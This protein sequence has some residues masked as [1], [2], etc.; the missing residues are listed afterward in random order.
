MRHIPHLDGWRGLAIASV[1]LGHFVGT[2]GF[3]SGRLGVDLFFVLSGLLMSRILFEERAQLRTF[4]LHRVSRVLPVFLL[5]CVAMILFTQV[6]AVRWTLTEIWTTLFFVRTYYMEIPIWSTEAPVGH[7]WSLNVEEHSYVLLALLAA[8]PF[9]RGREGWFLIGLG[10]AC[11]AFIIWYYK[12]PDVRPTDNYTLRTEC[13]AIG[14]FLAAGYRQLRLT[15]L[16]QPWMPIVAFALGVACYANEYVPS[17]AQML[18]APFLFAFA[19]NHI[20]DTYRVVVRAL[21]WRPLCLLG[22]WS[23]SVYLWQHPFYIYQDAFPAGVA[24]LCAMMVG[25][26]SFYLYE[27]PMRSWLNGFSARRLSPARDPVNAR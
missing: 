22:V 26:V 8:L 7:L 3:A 25:L 1:L 15:D 19:V 10:F 18:I 17:W 2:P 20:G 16:V 12:H 4:Y 21:E 9:M 11:A 23:F 24:L 14:I 13:A 6:A 27:K 5:F